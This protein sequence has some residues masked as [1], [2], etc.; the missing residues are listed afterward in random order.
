MKIGRLLLPGLEIDIYGTSDDFCII[1][2]ATIR[3]ISTLIGEL[4]KKAD[5]LRREHPSKLRKRVLLA[6]YTS[7]ALQDLVKRAKRR[8]FGY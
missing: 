4:G 7:L 5:R 3:A 1:S 6:I 8:E 2:E